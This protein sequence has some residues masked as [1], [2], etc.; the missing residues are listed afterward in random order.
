[1]YYGDFRGVQLAPYDQIM[2][3]LKDQKADGIN[4]DA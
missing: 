4:H 2:T 3:V 1:M